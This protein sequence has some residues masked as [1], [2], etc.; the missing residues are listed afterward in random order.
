MNNYLER[1][2][3]KAPCWDS[4]VIIESHIN[5]AVT[6]NRHPNLPVTHEEI[7]DE[8]IR[9]LDAGACLVHNHNTNFALKGEDAYEDYMKIWNKVFAKYPNALVYPTL[10]RTTELTDTEAGNE[11]ISLLVRRA[12]IKVSCMDPGAV[13]LA[14]REDDEGYLIGAPYMYN[15]TL[16]ARQVRLMRQT[17]TPI[18]FGCYEPGHM[19]MALHYID[20]GLAPKGSSLDFYLIG[21]YGLLSTTPVNTSGMPVTM[22]SLYFYLNMMGERKIPWYVSIWG[23][24]SMDLRPIMKRAVELGGHLRVGLEMYYDPNRPMS[25]VE[26]YQ[27]ACDIAREVG[28]PIATAEQY[29]SILKGEYTR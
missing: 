23:A 22:E 1:F 19:R 17:D 5:G 21:D 14:I 29:L 4:P 25:N 16:I 27:E 11:H 15:N 24:G 13:N 12:G 3:A 18:T 9:C 7:A 10:C 20:S 8:A 2:D 28:R 26:L 6:R